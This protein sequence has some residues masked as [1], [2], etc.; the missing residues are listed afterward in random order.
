MGL[1]HEHQ[2]PKE[3]IRWNRDA[4]IRDL[5]GPPNN[6]NAATIENNIFKKYQPG[7]VDATALD[8]KS[9][10]MYPIPAAWTENGY[11]STGMNAELSSTDKSFIFAAYPK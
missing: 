8:P 1:I 10:M 4:V 6:W 7:E 9:I 2:N 11:F 3:G 5:S